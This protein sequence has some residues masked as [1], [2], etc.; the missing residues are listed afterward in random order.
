L[1]FF[2]LWSSLRIAGI[3]TVVS[4]AAGVWLA[5]LLVNRQFPGRRELGALVTAAL[6]LPAPVICYYLLVERQH[7]WRWGMTGAA[8]VSA[9]PMLVRAGR[10]AFGSIEPVYGNVA[11]SLGC[12]DWRVFW[13]VE[14]PLVWR[15]TL[16]AAALA[17]T[18]VLAEFGA[19]VWIASRV[20]R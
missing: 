17:F 9:T 1:G 8:V 13:R 11:R 3:S 6:A 10:L 12:S 15:A 16:G 14:F 4:L 19:A 20:G 2:M 18:R 5:W 7:G